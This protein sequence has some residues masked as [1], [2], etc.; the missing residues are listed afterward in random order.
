MVRATLTSPSLPRGRRTTARARASRRE[1]PGGEPRLS[2]VKL[3]MC[4]Y[5]VTTALHA[6]HVIVG[7]FLIAWVA[8]RAWL[9]EYSKENHNFVHGVGL[10]WHFVDLVWIF[11]YPTLY[12]L[13]H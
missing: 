7:L 4:F 9:N 10:Y 1:S 12:L 2:H 11:L 3:F 13:R 6:L 8:V 5:F